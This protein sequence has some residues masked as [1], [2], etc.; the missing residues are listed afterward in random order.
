MKMYLT[1]LISTIN[2]FKHSS[3]QPQAWGITPCNTISWVHSKRYL[4][5][6][7]YSQANP[8]FLCFFLS[9]IA[10]TTDWCI[11][12]LK[13]LKFNVSRNIERTHS[14]NS[15]HNMLVMLGMVGGSICL[16]QFRGYFRT[17]HLFLKGKGM[18]HLLK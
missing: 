15:R 14:T 13:V 1:D 8:L 2:P 6:A 17:E 12:K 9:C 11:R 16:N 7:S 10:F 4:P 18:K 3:Y 5:V